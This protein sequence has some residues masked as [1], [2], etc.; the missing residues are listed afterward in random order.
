MASTD[1]LV[2]AGVTFVI[3][4]RGGPYTGYYT[5]SVRLHC[6]GSSFSFTVLSNILDDLKYFD[7][8]RLF[9]HMGTNPVFTALQFHRLKEMD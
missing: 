8:Y 4:E 1:Y 9:S 5:Y 3:N 2:V 6:L 7:L